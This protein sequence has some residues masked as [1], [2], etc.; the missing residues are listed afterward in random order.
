MKENAEVG[1]NIASRVQAWVDQF[2]QQKEGIG[3]VYHAKK[4]CVMTCKYCIVY[5]SK[6]VMC[7]VA[8]VVLY[9]R[10]TCVACSCE[11]VDKTL[12]LPEDVPARSS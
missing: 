10:H 8:T 1:G 9:Q 12:E 7:Y 6:G 11:P 3:C 5:V 2:T 4:R